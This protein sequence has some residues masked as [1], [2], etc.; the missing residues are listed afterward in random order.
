MGKDPFHADE[1]DVESIQRQVTMKLTSSFITEPLGVSDMCLSPA[2]I[3]SMTSNG[4]SGE[5]LEHV[6]DCSACFEQI[7]G[8]AELQL[9]SPPDFVANALRQAGRRTPITLER[10]LSKVT[11]PR[12]RL[13]LLAVGDG[14]I[15]IAK[16]SD[17]TID[18]RCDVIPTFKIDVRKQQVAGLK[19]TG[20]LVAKEGEVLNLV[21]VTKDGHPDMMAVHFP[22]ATLSARV[23][24]G[25]AHEQTVVDTV[26]VTG[27][28]GEDKVPFT[29]QA[30]L[31]F[32]PAGSEKK[33]HD[34]KGGV[35]G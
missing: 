1:D 10:E 15:Q 34:D 22:H 27:Y 28:L 21:D 12:P 30:R 11:E 4:L 14:T 35:V 31:T 29:A 2:E 9:Q 33:R 13:A 7:T 6:L 23:R 26:V 25:V 24:D 17:R 5:R 32:H 8:L 18:F 3:V 16:K 19:I 20:A